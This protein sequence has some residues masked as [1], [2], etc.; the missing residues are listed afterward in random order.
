[1]L[2]CTVTTII[3][4]EFKERNVKIGELSCRHFN[5][6]GRKKISVFS[7]LS[8]FFI[9]RK[10][11]TLLKHRKKDFA[12]SKED[13]VAGQMCQKWFGKF[14]KGYFSLYNTPSL[15]RLIG[16]DSSHIKTLIENNQ[17]YTTWE[18]VNIL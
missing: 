2:A 11:K 13:A 6:G 4:A 15:S 10:L 14:P 12:L 1:M 8:F 9:S 5:N 3:S 17:R 16:A 18:M 7:I